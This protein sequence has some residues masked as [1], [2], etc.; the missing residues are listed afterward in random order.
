MCAFV[1]LRLICIYMVH[2]ELDSCPNPKIG[3]KKLHTSKLR[4]RIRIRINA[5]EHPRHALTQPT[6][7]YVRPNI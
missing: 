7:S 6:T 2:H 1:L 4:I 3:N 5:G